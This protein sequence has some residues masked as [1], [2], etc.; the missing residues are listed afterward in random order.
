[1]CAVCCHVVMYALTP[2]DWAAERRSEDNRHECYIGCRQVPAVLQRRSATGECFPRR[3]C[4]VGE[5]GMCCPRAVVIQGEP[6]FSS[7]KPFPTITSSNNRLKFMV[8]AYLPFILTKKTNC[9]FPVNDKSKLE[10]NRNLNA[11]EIR[12][13]AA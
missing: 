11:T 6:D 3:V 7:H 4:L 8:C 10:R 2:A 13:I 1:M 9:K 5:R 12:C